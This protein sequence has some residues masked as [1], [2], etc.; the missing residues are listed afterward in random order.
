MCLVG[1]AMI[2]VILVNGLFSFWQENKAEE[3]VL[4]LQR[5]IRTG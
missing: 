1:D 5:L 4:A 3:A 2:G